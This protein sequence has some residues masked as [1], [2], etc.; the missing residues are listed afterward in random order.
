MNKPFFLLLAGAIMVA[1]VVVVGIID[2]GDDLVLDKT[3]EV[4]VEVVEIK[5]EQLTANLVDE[6]D[7]L[8]DDDFELLTEISLDGESIL[9][10]DSVQDLLDELADDSLAGFELFDTVPINCAYDTGQQPK[11][12]GVIINEVAWAGTIRDANDEWIELKNITSDE[13]D[14]TDWQIID[15]RE[16]I[17]AVL[18]GYI[19]PGGFYV[20]ERTDDDAVSDIV[21]DQ[22]YVG[23]LGNTNEGLRFFDQGCNLIDEV[24]AAPNWPAGSNADRRSMERL[25]DLT[26]HTYVSDDW[27]NVMGTPGK[28]NSEPRDNVVDLEPEPEIE[29]EI[30]PE[31]EPEVPDES[32]ANEPESEPSDVG[33]SV[34]GNVNHVVVSELQ[35]AGV[36]AGD[37][38]IELYNPTAVSV[39]LSGWSIQYLSGSADSVDSVVKKN[40][41]ADNAMVPRG[42]FLIARDKNSSDADGYDG[43]VAPDMAHR[44]FSMSGAS[45]GAKIFL[46]NDQNKIDSFTDSNIVDL[47]DYALGVPAAGQSLERRAFD[48]NNCVSAQGAGEALGN[49]CDSDGD[50]DFEVRAMADPQNSQSSNEPN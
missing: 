18:S 11:H 10:D 8:F 19:L 1:M 14:I 49:G 22:I 42:F 28:D 27:A 17:K 47:L 20:L 31:S 30:E 38:F 48:G 23:A 32:V 43:V 26:W 5:K 15:A 36:D 9:N 21:A 4:G 2:S 39:D 6:A 50:S 3:D 37:E 44:S 25:P 24:A 45:A 35:V 29:P 13:L 7:V 34:V 46:V 41:V 12:L 33:D 16:Q 40:F